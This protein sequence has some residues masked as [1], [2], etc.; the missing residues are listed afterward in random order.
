MSHAIHPPMVYK[1]P[2]CR[3]QKHAAC[4]SHVCTCLC[5]RPIGTMTAVSGKD[6]PTF[7]DD[8][9]TEDAAIIWSPPAPHP[10]FVAVRRLVMRGTERIAEAVSHTMARRIANALNNHTPN[11][12]GY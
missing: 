8:E 6:R 2:P 7:K 4:R 9:P 1:S 12:K 10:R 3:D 11:A 5:H